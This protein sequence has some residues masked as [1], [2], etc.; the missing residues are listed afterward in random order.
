VDLHWW[1]IKNEA[2]YRL[3]STVCRLAGSYSLSKFSCVGYS[4]GKLPDESLNKLAF[5]LSDARPLTW[6]ET[7]IEDQKQI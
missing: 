1:P 6:S 4:K 2:A 7:L 5:L 3:P